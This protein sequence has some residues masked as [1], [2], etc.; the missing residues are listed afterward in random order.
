[1]APGVV[2]TTEAFLDENLGEKSIA[3]ILRES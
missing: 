1:M 2:D 3:Q